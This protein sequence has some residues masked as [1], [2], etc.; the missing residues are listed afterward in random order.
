M[1]LPAAVLAGLSVPQLIE[2]G[3]KLAQGAIKAFDHAKALG[4][5]TPEEKAAIDA[6]TVAI[7]DRWDRVMAEDRKA[8]PDNDPTLPLFD[9]ANFHD[10]EPAPAPP[11]D[12]D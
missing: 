1:S 11:A 3:I 7:N 6:A 9:P 10:P 12:P 8:V 2:M 4:G 5:L